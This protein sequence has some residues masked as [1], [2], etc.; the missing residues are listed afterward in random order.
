VANEALALAGDPKNSD[1]LELPN[2]LHTLADSN[3]TQGKYEEAEKWARQAVEIHR[4]LHGNQHPETAWGL[5]ALGTALRG[6]QK[7]VD[8][9][10]P[11]REALSIFRE[12]YTPEHR[13]IQGVG[14][15]LASVLWAKGDRAGLEALAKEQAEHERRL[16]GPGYHVRLAELLLANESENRTDEARQLIWRAMDEYGRAAVDHPHEFIP[17]LNAAIGFLG[18]IKVCEEA[19]GSPL[20]LKMSNAGSQPSCR[21]S[22]PWRSASRDPPPLPTDSTI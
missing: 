3:S 6:Q 8:A 20:K 17:R 16:E 7:F 19:P 1:Y 21:N 4:R 18:L 12:Y 10:P 13:A 14:H 15:E 9:E 2:I 22:L 11:L 5:W